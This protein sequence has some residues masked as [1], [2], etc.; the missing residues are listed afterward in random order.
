LTAAHCAR[1]TCKVKLWRSGVFWSVLSFAGGL[2]NFACSSIIAHNLNSNIGEFG[3]STSALDFVN[4]LSLPLQML[5][6]SVIHY[7]AHFRAK[8]DEARLQ[9]LLA[10][11]QR[12]LFW[13]TVGGRVLALVLWQPLGRFFH[14]QKATVMAAVVVCG[15]VGWWS[16]FGMAL[17]QGMAWFKRIAVIALVAVG[18]RLLFAWV[19]T[20]QF[21]TAA[22][23]LSATTVS[24]LA[25]FI[26]F[27][28]WKDIFRH[29]AQRISPWTREFMQYLI[30]TGATVAGTYFFT[31]GD[32]LVS[33]KYFHKSDLDAYNMAARFGRAIPAMVLPLLIV[34]FT[35]RSG[36]KETAAR[37][38]QRILL[39]LYAAGLGCGAAVLILFRAP[40]VQLYLGH[41]N[42]AAAQMLV[43]FSISM[44]LI[45]LC[46]AVGMWSLADRTFK[47]ALLYGALGLGY[48]TTLLLV[49]TTPAALLSVMPIGAGISFCVLCVCWLLNRANQAKA[50]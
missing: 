26:L 2:G 40:V 44:V 28:W 7:I 49:G 32:G 14:F 38:D 36:G 3:A 42:E 48:W 34:T 30:V 41:P 47:I 25:N 11:C 37:T 10:G 16:G 27:Y 43:P 21:P 1:I 13:V 22:V 8:N 50:S 46:Q 31:T 24:L 9:G 33:N 18:I 29:P 12:F 19:M 20:K 5:N 45:G 23:A 39:S 35:S 17:C 4:L 15:M 6:M